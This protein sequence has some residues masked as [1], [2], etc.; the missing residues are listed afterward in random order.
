MEGQTINQVDVISSA[1]AKVL[2][3]TVTNDLMANV[4]SPEAKKM[5][6]DNTD[7]AFT[8]GAFG[9]PWFVATNARGTTLIDPP[10]QMH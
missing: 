9:L 3:G 5:L 8:E 4:S 10:S 6:S 7:K 1:L 2:G